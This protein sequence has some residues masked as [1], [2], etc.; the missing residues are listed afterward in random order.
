MDIS[1]VILSWNSELYLEKCL[2]SLISCLKKKYSKYEIFVVDNGSSDSSID[3]LNS[4]KNDY[5]DY[6]KLILLD[7]NKGTTFPRNLAL[8]QAQGEFI[9]IMDSDTEIV[10]NVI[11]RLTHT[12]KHQNDLGLV[13]PRLVYGKGMLQKSV[14]K[15]PTILTKLNRFFFLKVS[16]KLNS[17]NVNH[18]R[19][20]VDYAISAMWVLKKE[21][22]V[23]I[24]LLDEKIFYAPEDVDYCIRI[25]KGGYKILYVPEV[26][27][28]HYGQEISRGFKINRATI[29]HVKGLFYYFCKHKYF[30]K[31]PKFY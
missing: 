31:K 27:A 25:W 17:G 26:Y 9:V 4:F 23:N 2:S 29:E 8:K 10:E 19:R 30:L 1:V 15:F 16:E 6:I 11:P 14:D 24:G 5:S 12:L 18:E 20:E 13:A 7:T 3:I 21:L 28:I 22:I